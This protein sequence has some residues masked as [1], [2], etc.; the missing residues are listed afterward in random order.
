MV[1]IPG[2][3]S[4]SGYIEPEFSWEEVQ[5]F[6]RSKKMQLGRD[7]EDAK[8]WSAEKVPPC[9]SCGATAEGLLW[10]YYS[11]SRETWESLCGR[12]AWVIAC[13][14][15]RKHVATVITLIS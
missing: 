15:C 12:E 4:W 11:S 8:K 2:T 10:V 9:P 3:V 14:K 6:R 13:D 7:P 5:R 1:Q